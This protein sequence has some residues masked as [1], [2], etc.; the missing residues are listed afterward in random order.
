MSHVCA[1]KISGHVTDSKNQPLPFSSITIK[2]TTQGT[3]ANNAGDFSI[4]LSEGEYVFVVQHI[5]YKTIE[6]KVSV[7]RE[8]MIVN[9]QLSEQQ[10]DLGNVVVKQGE[11]PAY[12]IIRNAIKKRKYYETELKKFDA[13]VYLKGQLRTRNYPK[14]FLGKDVDFEDGDTSKKKMVFLSETVARY[15]VDEPHKKVEVISTKVSGDKDA[16]GFS[17]PQIFSFYQNIISLGNLNPRGFISPIS[18]NALNYYRYKFEGSFFENNQM[19]N[20]IKVI[21]KRKYEPL[22]NGHINI[23]E[24]EWRIQSVQLVL[25]KENQMQFA[26]TLTIQQLYVPVNGVW[27]IKQQTLSPAIK[28]LGFDMAGTFVQVYDN[29]NLRPVFAKGFFNNTVFKFD[30]SSNKKSVTYWDSIRPVPLLEEE[31]KDYKKKDSL[32]L[33]RKDPHYLDSLD[34]KRNKHGLISVLLTGQ[35]FTRAKTKSS[36]QVPALLSTINFNTVEGTVIDIAPT[37]SKRFSDVKRNSL[38]ITPNLRYGFSNQHFNG[39]L[40]NAYYYGKKYFNSITVSGGKR[41]FQ[42]D[43]NNPISPEYNTIST[44]RYERNYM[45]IYEAAFGRINYAKELGRGVTAD[46]DIQYQDRMPLQNTTTTKWRDFPDR[47]FTPNFTFVPH[48]AL[49]ASVVVKWKPGTRYVEFPNQKINIGSAYPTF[50]LSYTQGIK[51]ALQSAVDYSK[52]KFAINH[53]L[54]LKLFGS[55]NYNIAAAGFLR[56]D[57]VFF[58]DYQHYLGNQLT[59]VSQSLNIFQLMPYYAYSNTERFYSTAHINYHLNGLLT[60]KLPLLKKLNWFLVVGTNLLY[61]NNG[62]KYS[63]VSVGLENILKVLRVDF[64]KSF[65]TDNNGSTGIR[66]ALP[67]AGSREERE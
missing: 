6:R 13:E 55:V 62:T 46:A 51:G 54:N 45:K 24:N 5:G 50:S 38:S 60:N 18:D 67:L 41:V 42:F 39:W 44:L 3:T 11:D 53:T 12:A 28:L 7:S 56:N 23:I 10:Y 21:P 4:S 36:L 31:V 58:P 19:V 64:V 20:R 14:K 27:I 40:R 61:L 30:D 9:F 49:V 8:E 16:F 35:T 22:F 2:G 57:A 25:Y 63:E 1:G 29:M 47:E 52:W 66:I 15:S 65:A 34:R 43:N 48:R 33:V 17:N 37:Y 32:E 26:D 59:V